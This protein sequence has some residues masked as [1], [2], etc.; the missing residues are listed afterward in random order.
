VGV[1][2]AAEI[3]VWSNIL[4]RNLSVTVGSNWH[5]RDQL[6]ELDVRYLE[7]HIFVL[8]KECD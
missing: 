3:S 5:E 7:S 2:C 4:I 8:N 6:L 1:K